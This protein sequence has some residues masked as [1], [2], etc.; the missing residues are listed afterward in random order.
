MEVALNDIFQKLNIDHVKINTIQRTPDDIFDGLKNFGLLEIKE[1][2]MSDRKFRKMC[3][4]FKDEWLEPGC[5]YTGA[6]WQRTDDMWNRLKRQFG[7]DRM[8]K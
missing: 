1:E 7:V 6:K 3:K 4:R 2:D 5:S 8:E